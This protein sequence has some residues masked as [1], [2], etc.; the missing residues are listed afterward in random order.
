MIGPA[1]ASN[2]DSPITLARQRVLRRYQQRHRGRQDLGLISDKTHTSVC[3]IIIL[4]LLT[5]HQTSRWA[6][7]LLRAPLLSVCVYS[8]PMVPSNDCWGNLKQY[9]YVRCYYSI[10]TMYIS[11]RFWDNL[12]QIMAWF[13]NLGYGSLKVIENGTSWKLW[14][15]LLLALHS[16]YGRILRHFRDNYKLEVTVHASL[17]AVQGYRVSG[18]LLYTS[19]RHSQPTSFMVSHSTSPDH[20]T[21]PAQHFRSSG[22]LC[23]WSDSLELATGQSP[24]PGAHQ[25]QLQAMKTNLFRRYQHTQR[26]RDA[27]WLCAI[28]YWHWHTLRYWSK[29]TNFFYI[30][31]HSTPPFP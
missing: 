21:L 23:R 4:L 30:F 13:W 7:K 11:Y 12:R 9:A 6:T 10:V 14:H 24:R 25:Q 16:N 22:L 18:R 8:Q 31:L 29:I 20:N 2:P 15:G 26:S 19:L 28:Y 17:S 27:T 3:R 5:E 1:W